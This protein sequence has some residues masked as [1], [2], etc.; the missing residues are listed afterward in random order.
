MRVYVV[1]LCVLAV[2]MLAGCGGGG[3][4]TTVLP[5]SV[6]LSVPDGTT[7]TLGTPSVI[8]K[9]ADSFSPSLVGS[10]FLAAA[11]CTPAGTSFNQAVTLTFNLTTA[12]A[13]GKTVALFTK[14]T[15]NNITQV[16]GASVT[17]SADR[18]TATVQVSSFP[19]TKDYILLIVP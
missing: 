12:V 15:S 16:N 3:G 4:T 13:D 11:T 1:L 10:A 19:T 7:S 2:A 18:K 9:T 5:F 8:E 17:L 6:G 14:D